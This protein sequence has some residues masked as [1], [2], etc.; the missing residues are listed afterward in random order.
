MAGEIITGLAVLFRA[1]DG[2]NKIIQVVPVVEASEKLGSPRNS[3][4][5]IGVLLLACTTI[6]AIPQTAVIGAILLTG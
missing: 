5:G 4:P 1:F 6:Y 2:A 3:I